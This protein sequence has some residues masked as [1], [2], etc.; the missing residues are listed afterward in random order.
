MVLAYLIIFF[1]GASFASFI[2][3][4]AIRKN[5]MSGRS[6]CDICGRKIYWYGLTPVLGYVFSL[7]RC[8]FCKK[9]IPVWNL[10]S[11]ISLGAIMTTLVYFYGFSYQAYV[12]L[13]IVLILF[14]LLSFDYHNMILPD[15]AIILLAVI[16]LI[17][18]IYFLGTDVWEILLTALLAALP[19]GILYVY[20]R[21]MWLGLGDIKLIFALSLSLGYPWAAISIILGIWSAAAFG[22][23]LVMFKRATL[24]SALP[25]GSFLAFTSILV[26]LF[27]NEFQIV[28]T[29]F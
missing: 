22:L 8:R 2:N 17:Y 13:A 25:F 4:L 11:E 18:Q 16:G 26:I 6:K 9:K 1:L 3:V 23:I 14:Y 15:A 7:G 12:A 28:N 21:G 27:Q 10:V 24:K 19:F 20:S 5:G 29:L